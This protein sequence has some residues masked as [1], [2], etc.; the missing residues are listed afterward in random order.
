M[1]S[2]WSF[3][4]LFLGV[5]AIANAQLSLG[6]AHPFRVIAREHLIIVAEN[7]SSKTLTLETRKGR[8]E[9]TLPIKGN[10]PPS[11]GAD[12]SYFKGRMTSLVFTGSGETQDRAT[13]YA[14]WDGRFWTP[15]ASWHDPSDRS[16]GQK[17]VPWKAFQLEDDRFL[18]FGRFQP[19]EQEA[20]C[21]LAIARIDESKRLIIQDYL[22][23]R[24]GFKDPFF[25]KDGTHYKK[26][27]KYFS[28]L[29]NLIWGSNVIETE[30]HIIF[31]SLHD[32]FLLMFD[33]MGRFKGKYALFEEG[34]EGNSNTSTH[35]SIFLS[36]APLRDGRI[37]IASPTR[38]A[39]EK[40][41]KE[42]KYSFHASKFW[43]PENEKAMAD[44]VRVYPNFQWWTFDPDQG[45][46]RPQP[47]P[48][49]VPTRFAGLA[50]MVNFA[51]RPRLDD[52]L[53]VT[54]FQGRRP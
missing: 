26:N 14:S 43:S 28:F 31:P 49:G 52:S 20:P 5:H 8:Q 22:N 16:K 40:A 27:K 11:I 37:L 15:L 9:F 54:G 30:N 48:E 21:P 42:F 34:S 17:C 1:A 51:F 41:A 44:A 25:V 6:G 53:E 2:R 50:E 38:E 12:F 10:A 35:V 32:G 47:P 39:I 3:W 13:L 4:V 19:R 36:L 45:T 33:R 23:D 29:Q 46:F 24:L 7:H 18:L